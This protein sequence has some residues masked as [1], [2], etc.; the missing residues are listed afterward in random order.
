MNRYLFVRER[1]GSD[2]TYFLTSLAKKFNGMGKCIVI[3]DFA[4][5]SRYGR[6]EL[7]KVLSK[8]YIDKNIT[9]SINLMTIDEVVQNDKKISVMI[10][11]ADEAKKFLFDIMKYFKIIFKVLSVSVVST[12]S[13]D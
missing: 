6:T 7:M 9:I 5:F 10:S 12:D 13:Y 4:E 1:S 8:D 2:K 3:L 11:S